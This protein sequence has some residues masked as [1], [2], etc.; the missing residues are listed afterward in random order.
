M[1]CSGASDLALGNTEWVSE[2]PDCKVQHLDRGASDHAPLLLKVPAAMARIKR[3]FRFELLWMEYEECQN[4]VKETWARHAGGNPMH[5]FSHRLSVLRKTLST[6]N[7]EAVGSVERRLSDTNTKLANLEELDA[8]GQLPEEGM[9]RLR[10]LYNC[11]IAL[12]RQLNIKWLQRSRLRWTEDGD[13]NTKFFH[14]SATIRRKRNK[15][16]GILDGEDRWVQAPEEVTK[17][18]RHSTKASGRKLMCLTV[19]E[20]NGPPYPKFRARKRWP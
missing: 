11:K 13:R 16:S 18:L 3:P 12:N 2:H 4:I 15:I 6:W 19:G 9:Q 1:T 10:S 8:N 5:A 7:R 17:S 14:I 20:L